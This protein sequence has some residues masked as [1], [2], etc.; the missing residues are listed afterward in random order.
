MT[1]FNWDADE[2]DGERE[3]HL[4]QHELLISPKNGRFHDGVAGAREGF[5]IEW[6]K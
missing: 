1:Y 4:P 3:A 6:E 2:P 5:V